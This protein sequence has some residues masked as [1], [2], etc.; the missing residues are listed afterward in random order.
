MYDYAQEV[1]K[2]IKV[3]RK[4]GYGSFKATLKSEASCEIRVAYFW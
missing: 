4:E 2:R 1:S 3:P